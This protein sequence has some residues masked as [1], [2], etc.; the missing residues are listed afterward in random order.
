M[1]NELEA[2]ETALNT[3]IPS[4]ETVAP[5][6]PETVAVT[7]QL[8][9]T[10]TQA[11]EQGWVPLE[12]WKASGRSADEWR[13]AKDFVERGELFKSIHSTKREL[14]QT[15]A[16]LDALNRHHQYVFEKAHQQAVRDL[17]AE[18][19]LAIRNEDLDRL[20][21][22][23]TEIEQMTDQHVKERQVMAAQV[24]QAA[25][26]GGPV[27]EFQA[28]VEAN[29]WYVNNKGLRNEADAIGFVHLNNGGTRETLL[30]HVAKEIKRK[31]PEEFGPVK[32]S[33]PSAVAAPARETKATKESDVHLNESER[34]V[35]RTFVR[36]GVM[37]EA[38][39]RAELKRVKDRS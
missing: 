20:E 7:P 33:A 5:S 6:T 37:T 8:S 14:K 29:P 34:E 13:P 36:Q 11:M 21:E 16:A 12:D 3:A 19:R 27:P 38:Q 18:K 25:S 9:P 2:A 28:F 39:Y 32:R 22:I 31:F 23:E 4:E 24:A 17:R 15:Q 35:M 1:S 30:A 26:A 10:E